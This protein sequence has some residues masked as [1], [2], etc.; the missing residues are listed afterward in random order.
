MGVVE[1]VL[2]LRVRVE[3][4]NPEWAIQCPFRPNKLD[5]LS[6][7]PG[8]AEFLMRQD[9]RVKRKVNPV[10]ALIR[11]VGPSGKNTVCGARGA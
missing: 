8:V 7:N 2:R 4:L 6:S 10:G 3:P 1:R 9:E 5:V 11:V